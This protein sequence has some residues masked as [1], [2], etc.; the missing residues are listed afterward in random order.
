V[1]DAYLSDKFMDLS[2]PVLGAVRARSLLNQLWKLDRL[3][4]VTP[5]IDRVRP[6]EGAQSRLGPFGRSPV[7]AQRMSGSAVECERDGGV[8]LLRLARPERMNALT[9]EIKSELCEL[10]PQFFDDP[11]ARCLLI[12]A[13]VQRSARRRVAQFSHRPHARTDPRAAGEV[14][15]MG[16]SAHDRGEARDHGRQWSSRRCG[17]WTRTVG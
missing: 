1:D 15:S 11:T 8:T 6:N 3:D 13:V 7:A 2:G 5:V 9:D 16:A 17:I 14:P 4:D 10:I 12:T